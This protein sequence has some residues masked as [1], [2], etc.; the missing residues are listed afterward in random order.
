MRTTLLFIL[1]WFGLFTTASAQNSILDSVFTL[2]YN[3][4][5]NSAEMLLES[6]KSNITPVYFA[7]L[8]ID[9]AYWKNV[10]NDESKDYKVFESQL[11]K[12]H[13]EL[14][15]NEDQKIIQ[16]ITLSY[17][18]RYELKRL[19]LF[20]AISTRK[21]ALELFLELSPSANKLT[22]DQRELFKLYQS[23]VTYFDYYMKPPF[24]KNKKQQM[25]AAIRQMQQLTYAQ[26]H[27]VKTLSSY[28]LGKVYLRFERD[29]NKGKPYFLWLKQTY[30]GNTR[31]QEL[32]D[33]CE[34]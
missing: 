14:T 18:L 10:I 26:N 8:A 23:L 27:I 11:Q 13:Q 32:L 34:S 22:T 17:Q 15:E 4:K 3:Q 33:E 28:F 20:S 7:V 12:Y 9:M 30:P 1:I 24:S 19:R 25:D 21:K 6:N 31:F 16:L 5:Y 2:I 29:A